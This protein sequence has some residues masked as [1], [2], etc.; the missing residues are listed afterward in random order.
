MIITS[1]YGEAAVVVVKELVLMRESSLGKPRDCGPK[2]A[3]L[4]A[5]IEANATVGTN[6][7]LVTTIVANTTW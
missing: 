7:E 6:G 1:L 2:G 4:S 3:S 5:L